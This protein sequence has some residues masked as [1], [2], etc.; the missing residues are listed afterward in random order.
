MT[1]LH[2]VVPPVVPHD[3]T[4]KNLFGGHSL[5]KERRAFA[6]TD[7]NICSR[8]AFVT[9][10]KKLMVLASPKLILDGNDFHFSGSLDDKF[11]TIRPA[12]I[13][14]AYNM[15]TVLTLGYKCNVEK[16]GA[17]HLHDV[18]SMTPKDPDRQLT[19]DWLQFGEL[20]HDARE[21]AFPS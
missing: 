15:M 18:Y 4:I 6:Y 3:E 8:I 13:A 1:H 11:D 10:D 2:Q 20:D 14:Q 12:T 19:Q 16:L 21:G 9:K 7:P 5:N 17:A